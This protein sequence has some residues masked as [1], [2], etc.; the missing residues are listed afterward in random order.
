MCA[1]ADDCDSI[2]Q[3][4]EECYG[5]IPPALTK[6]EKKWLAR[7]VE[8]DDLLNLTAVE[9][10]EEKIEDAVEDGKEKVIEEV[11]DEV[12]VTEKQKENMKKEAEK[13][14]KEIEKLMK[15][16]AEKHYK[17]CK[18]RFYDEKSTF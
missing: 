2:C 12:A 6:D 16:G 17:K 14:K 18:E 10:M 15:G 8:I 13:R 1:G 5:P 4:Y 11:N 9:K 3:V 7:C